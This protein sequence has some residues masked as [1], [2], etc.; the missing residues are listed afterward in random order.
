MV[1]TLIFKDKL[2]C[3]KKQQ[4]PRSDQSL[5]KRNNSLYY[6]INDENKNHSQDTF[7]TRSGIMG[8]LKHN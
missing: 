3:K 6:D 8:F 2:R 1:V 5:M 4:H 7:H